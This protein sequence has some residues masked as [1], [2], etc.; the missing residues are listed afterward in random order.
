MPV[1]QKQGKQGTEG[2]PSPE[3]NL[4]I[5]TR[6]CVRADTHMQ[7]VFQGPLHSPALFVAFLGGTH[8]T[9]KPFTGSPCHMQSTRASVTQKADGGPQTPPQVSWD[10]PSQTCGAT[11]QLGGGLAAMGTARW[12]LRKAIMSLQILYKLPT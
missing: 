12:P 3:L 7:R 8:E 2:E 5:S 1:V 10:R 11:T 4:T 9:S 6:V